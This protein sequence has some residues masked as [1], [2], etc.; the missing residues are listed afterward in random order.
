MCVITVAHNVLQINK[1]KDRQMMERASKSVKFFQGRVGNSFAGQFEGDEVEVFPEY[2]QNPHCLEGFD[3]ALVWLKRGRKDLVIDCVP[4]EK[5]V[6]DLNVREGESILVTG[7]PGDDDGALYEQKGKIRKVTFLENKQILV[8][9]Q[10][11]YTSP[12]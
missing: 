4:L 9:Y 10:D 1:G 2:R 8:H 11:I 6:E 3:L 12:G 7:Y 5:S